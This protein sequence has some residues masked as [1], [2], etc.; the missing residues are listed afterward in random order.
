MK[1]SDC[2]EFDHIVIGSG[3]AGLSSA[4][5]L[6]EA[7]AS[8]AII[9]KS[10]IDECNT[11]L[12]QG[13]IACVLDKEDTFESHIQDTLYAGAG[14]CKE[15][16][17][18]KI[19]E[20]GPEVVHEFIRRGAHFTTRGELGEKTQKDDFDLGREGGHS[21]RRVLHAG[22]ITGEEIERILIKSCLGN[23]KI[24]IFKNHISIDLIIKRRDKQQGRHCVGVYAL[25]RVKGIVK[26]FHGVTTTIATG[27]SGKVYLYTSNPDIACGA[28]VAMGYRA[29]VKIANMEFIQFH[30]T[31]L[32][33]PSIRSFLISEA[34]RGEGAV[35]KCRNKSGKLVPFM[36]KYH[37][38]ESLAPRDVVARAIDSE[39]KRLG[40]ECVYLD[41]THHSEK[42]LR[43]RFP[44][45]FKKCLEAGVNM[46]KDPIPVVPAAH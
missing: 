46:A 38:M 8:V 10:A 21:Q 32:Y 11:K 22:D 15:D 28:G 31:I 17:V 5:H 26:T 27:G 37:P 29:G 12:A 7:G 2:L 25:D 4:L 19:I 35:L 45:I 42:T 20:T 9:T 40:Q 43:R 1:V 23:E 14:L 44:N 6:A 3:V 30:P 36:K 18:R 33:H 39:M 16:V 13:G 24:K 41:I 34:V